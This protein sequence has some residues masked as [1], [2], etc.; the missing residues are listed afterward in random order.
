M[1]TF[2]AYSHAGK[3]LFQA[4]FLICLLLCFWFWKSKLDR[5]DMHRS[6]VCAGVSLDNCSEKS[7]SQR[8][9]TIK[10]LWWDHDKSSDENESSDN[11]VESPVELPFLCPVAFLQFQVSY[12]NV[13]HTVGHSSHTTWSVLW[14]RTMYNML[15]TNTRPQCFV[16][17]VC[18]AHRCLCDLDIVLSTWVTNTQHMS[19]FRANSTAAWLR[20]FLCN[21]CY[22]WCWS[23]CTPQ[24]GHRHFHDNQESVI[25][26]TTN[27][28]LTQGISIL[29][30][31]FLQPDIAS[32]LLTERLHL[33]E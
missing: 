7:F 3:T 17:E 33:I 15:F 28:R 26:P 8:S 10:F 29:P 6:G 18:T 5:A 31:C 20:L 23:L 4:C 12:Q 25:P 11:E 2:A 14:T 24:N 22:P 9:V 13:D 32:S 19:S 27:T 16:L 1:L 30:F 21:K